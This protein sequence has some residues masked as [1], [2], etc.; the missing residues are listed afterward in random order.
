MRFPQVMGGS[1]STPAHVRTPFLYLGN[2][3]ADSVELWCVFRDPLAMRFTQTKCLEHLHVHTC[4]PLLGT[5]G[6]AGRIALNFGLWVARSNG[7]S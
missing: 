2:G 6:T 4:V 1:T 3:W 5:S 7:V